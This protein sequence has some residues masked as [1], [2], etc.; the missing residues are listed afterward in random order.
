[1]PAWPGVGEY[2]TRE[3]NKPA[4]PNT[5]R[6]GEPDTDAVM[7]DMQGCA[8]SIKDLAEHVATCTGYLKAVLDELRRSR[9]YWQAQAFEARKDKP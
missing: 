5:R 8:Q 6:P 4:C 1:M 2:N 3:G 9:N 7:A